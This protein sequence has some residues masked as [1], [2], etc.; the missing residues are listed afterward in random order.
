MEW[1]SNPQPY[2]SVQNMLKSLDRLNCIT[3][4]L[5]LVKKGIGN[6]V[7]QQSQ[8]IIHQLRS[9]EAVVHL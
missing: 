7:H 1:K 5:G 9:S 8:F 4:V 6:W 3:V 2:E